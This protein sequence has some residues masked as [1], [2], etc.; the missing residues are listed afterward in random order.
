M[1][2]LSWYAGLTALLAAVTLGAQAQ[3]LTGG[4]LGRPTADYAYI[5]PPTGATLGCVGMFLGSPLNLQCDAGLTYDAGTDTLTTVKLMLGTARVFA[6]AS[7]IALGV[8]TL[9]SATGE[10]NIAFGINAGAVLA[11]DRNVLIGAYS[12]N[13]LGYAY[14]N[15]IVGA[16]AL[17]GADGALNRTLIGAA[18]TGSANN[19]VVL[20]N[21]SV[22]EV[23]LGTGGVAGGT[24]ASYKVLGANGETW[25]RGYS[26]ELLT[27]STAGTTTDTT[28][29]L[30]PANAIIEAV[31][32]RVTTT[33]TTATDWQLGDATTPGRFTTVNSTLVA[34]TTDTGLV[35]IDQSGAAGPRQTAAAKVRVT[36][37]GTPGAGAVRLT[38]FWRQF[39]PP[40]T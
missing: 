19:Q 28:G 12:G 36:T 34:G 15:T 7:N 13:S 30:L 23:Q 14:D 9:G 25:V 29:N 17:P 10:G 40:S 11:G 6:D 26:T 21:T 16:Q 22:T 39:T 37:T 1:R 20:G 32:A 31:V 18:A 3:P 2:K 24:A 8:G 33:I 27:L 38:V 5:P 35:H 4:L